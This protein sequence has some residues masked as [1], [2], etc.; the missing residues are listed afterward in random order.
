MA[1][2]PDVNRLAVAYIGCASSVGHAPR[3]STPY[4]V[5]FAPVAWEQVGA[6]ASDA[7]GNLNHA[8]KRLAHAAGTTHWQSARSVTALFSLEVGDVLVQYTFDHKGRVIHVRGLR[9]ILS[10]PRAAASARGSAG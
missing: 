9:G 1:W 6:M 2:L 3:M 4:S 7:F 5:Q 10:A 8:L